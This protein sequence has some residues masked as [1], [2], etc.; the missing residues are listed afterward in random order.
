MVVLVRVLEKI[1]TSTVYTDIV[2]VD[3]IF[4]ASGRALGSGSIPFLKRPTVLQGVIIKKI[5]DVVTTGEHLAV[6]TV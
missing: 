3:M 6:G 1:Y 4:K 2:T 5:L